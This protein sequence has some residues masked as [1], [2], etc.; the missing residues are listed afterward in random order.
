[1]ISSRRDRL[2]ASAGAIAALAISNPVFRQ[3]NAGQLNILLVGVYAGVW[4]A[5]ARGAHPCVAGSIAAFGTLLKL[6]PGILLLWFLFTRRFREA[7]WMLGAMTLF[8]VGSVALFG[9]PRHLEFLPVLGQMGFGK[10]TWAEYGNTFWRDEYNLSV[11]AL[12]HRAFVDRPSSGITPIASIGEGAANL[13]T[14]LFALGVLG[15]ACWVWSLRGAASASYA[16]AIIVSL[17]LPSIFWDHY[18]VQLSVPVLLLTI[19][20]VG[21]RRFGMAAVIVCLFLLLGVPQ[22][23]GAPE[24]NSGLGILWGSAKLLPVLI[25]GVIAATTAVVSHKPVVFFKS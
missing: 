4:I 13:L 6:S 2:L 15:V 12:L 21:E 18:L 7:A 8:T 17:L 3:V 20:A 11:N 1:M 16:T 24:W 10:S 23:I 25:L 5:L 14:M 19:A 9:L 22:Q